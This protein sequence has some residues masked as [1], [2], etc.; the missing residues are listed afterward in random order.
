MTDR[1][2]RV[3]MAVVAT[4]T[5]GIAGYLLYVHYTGGSAVCATGGCETVQQSAYS[6]IFGIP[7]ALVGLLGSVGILLTLLR[8]DIYGRAA[9]LSL[10]LAG[11]SFAAYLVIVQLAVLDAVCEWCVANDA[12]VAV[13]AVLGAW[14]ARADLVATA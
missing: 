8:G 5:I 13:L 14:R 10:A 3:A 6:E 4:A 12:L 7:V 2:L 11:L 1:A 9:G